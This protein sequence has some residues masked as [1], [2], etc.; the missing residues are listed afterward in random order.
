MSE[1][2]FSIDLE[3]FSKRLETKPTWKKRWEDEHQKL[4][5]AADVDASWEKVKFMCLYSTDMTFTQH[6]HDK[7][8]SQIKTSKAG[9]KNIFERHVK[10]QA[11]LGEYVTRV[12]A[13]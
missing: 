9:G 7:C 4:S 13:L 1:K 6:K 2:S 12:I 5:I 10:L 11:D 3:G 8:S